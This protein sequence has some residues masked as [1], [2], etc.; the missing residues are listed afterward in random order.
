MTVPFS[1]SLS[2]LMLIPTFAE[3]F[4]KNDTKKI[5]QILFEN[6][7]NVED[8]VDEVVCTHRNLRGQVINCLR[9]ESTERMDSEWLDSGV[10]SWEAKVASINDP[11]MRSDLKYMGQQ[12]SS[13]KAFVD[14][15]A[16]AEAVKYDK[17]QQKF[18]KE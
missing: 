4:G 2:D 7:M 16:G 9:Y 5:K 11:T 8:I 15:S 10:A 18:D 3:A 13:E 6:G 14:E 17:Q 12:G 1:L